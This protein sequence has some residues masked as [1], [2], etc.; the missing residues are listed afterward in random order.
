[1][2]KATKFVALAMTAALG[3]SALAG[4]QG[5][6]STA[7]DASILKIGGIGPTTGGAAM[8]GLGVK[9]AAELAVGTA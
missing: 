5:D 7:G 2:K 1:M 4:C 9:H 8:Y 3:L 6:G